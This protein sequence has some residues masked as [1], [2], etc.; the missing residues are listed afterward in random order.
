MHVNEDIEFF[1]EDMNKPVV[2]V[3]LDGNI[4]KANYRFE[5]VFCVGE[6]KNM[7]E[8]ISCQ[9]IDTWNQILK[10]ICFKK[11]A[12]FEM[13]VFII[14]RQYQV[15]VSLLYD[16]R[17]KKVIVFFNLP[18][19]FKRDREM[20]WSSAFRKSDNLLIISNQDGYI[21]EINDLTFEYFAIPKE[22]FIGRNINLIMELF[23]EKSLSI[24]K[25][26][27][28][29]HEEGYAETLQQYIHPSEHIR[30]Y[31]IAAYQDDYS[32]LILTKISDQT[33]MSLLKQQLAHKGSLLEVG[34]LAAS[35]AHEIRNPITTLKGFTQLLKAT[36]SEETLK[37]LNVIDDEITRMESILS[38][39]L[40]LS[41]PTTF[42]KEAILLNSLLSDIIQVFYPKA[43]QESISIHEKGNFDEEFW[44]LGDEGKLK[45]VILNLFK[46]GLEAMQTGGILSIG[47]ESDEQDK[48][49]V[50]IQDTGKGMD[51][52]Q[53]SQVFM[54]YFTTRPEGT[55]LGLPFV[56][57][58]VEDHDGKISVSSELG[59]GTK[60]II[61][62][63][64][65]EKNISLEKEQ[66]PTI[67]QN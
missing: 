10:E 50:V 39:M 54:P 56:L 46:N 47:L 8:I 24:D 43:T 59:K 40:F 38:E 1:L 62:F 11:R 34:Q 53:L 36:A 3:D 30:Y 45:Q 14:D 15:K 55:G 58:T 37:Y 12:T 25:F 35:I 64:I 32:N 5:Y 66:H 51:E 41:K 21:K 49:S 13:H 29:V 28:K 16:E 7:K 23:S 57:K 67:I 33:E 27:K 61:T 20:N 9:S 22:R 19:S 26:I 31:H 17:D 48:V 52:S 6:N 44:I 65:V 60:F 42:E 63:P 4:S 2:V 18:L